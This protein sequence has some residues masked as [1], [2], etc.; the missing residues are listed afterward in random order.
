MTDTPDTTDTRLESVLAAA[1]A[2][3]PHW[4]DTAPRDRAAALTAIA[5]ALDTHTADLVAVAIEETGLPE[6]RLTGELNRTRVQLRM[7][8]QELLD[9]HFLDVILDRAD[10]DFVLGPRPDLRRYQIP[11]GPVLVFAAG[12]FPFAFSV[13]GTDTAS[14]LAAG[15]PVLLKAHPGHPR[16]SAA[17]A[18]VVTAALTTAGAPAGIFALITGF[19]AGTRALQDPRITAAAF[20]GSVAGGRA[21]FD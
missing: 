12:N 5:A 2:A 3:A 20:T 15:C 7:F 17:T 13:A 18:D 6:A 21:L 4:E 8:A 10:P 14:A 11:T 16:T 19:R 1:A 9:G